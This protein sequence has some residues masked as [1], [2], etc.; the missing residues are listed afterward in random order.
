LGGGEG[1]TG[2]V[3]PSLPTARNLGDGHATV[4]E[5]RA[6]DLKRFKVARAVNATVA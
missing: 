6:D 2:L 1:G 4:T 3:T 5:H